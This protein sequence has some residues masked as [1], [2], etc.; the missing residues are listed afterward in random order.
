M[1]LHL[2]AAELS[3]LDLLFAAA[4]HDVGTFKVNF[5]PVSDPGVLPLLSP[6]F[7]FRQPSVFCLV[8]CMSTVVI[9]LDDT[10]SFRLWLLKFQLSIV[11]WQ[12]FP[13]AKLHCLVSGA[14]HLLL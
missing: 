3:L 10:I 4:V 12:I 1:A 13:V 7:T 5:I 8:C 11:I 6:L 2:G 9:D 14:W